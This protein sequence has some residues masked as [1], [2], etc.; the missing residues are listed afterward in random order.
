[1]VKLGPVKIYELLPIMPKNY[2]NNWRK[3]HAAGTQNCGIFT[4]HIEKGKLIKC[5]TSPSE[6]FYSILLEKIRRIDEQYNDIIPE[7]YDIQK[8]MSYVNITLK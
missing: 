4:S 2:L 8:K 1:M 3:I 6:Y 5:S 7:I